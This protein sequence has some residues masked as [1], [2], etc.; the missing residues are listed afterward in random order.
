MTT[1]TTRTTA[2]LLFV[3]QYCFTG[4]D[5][6]EWTIVASSTRS[7]GLV[8]TS[9]RHVSYYCGNIINNNHAIQKWNASKSAS[10]IAMPQRQHGDIGFP[11][12]TSISSYT[13]Y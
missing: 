9:D 3:M 6:N 5:F 1:P 12:R 8:R 10:E 7:L 13:I 2:Q 11:I 4:R